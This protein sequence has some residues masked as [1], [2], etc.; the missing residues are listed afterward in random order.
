MDPPKEE[1]L[2]VFLS[3]VRHASAYLAGL[4]VS[5]VGD[6]KAACEVF[7]RGG[8]PTTPPTSS[9][10]GYVLRMFHMARHGDFELFFRWFR[11]DGLGHVDRLAVTH[12]RMDLKA[13]REHPH[14]RRVH[15]RSLGHRPFR[16]A[17]QHD[18]R[19]L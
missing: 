15:R 9:I 8:S 16:C 19:A 17:A 14:V 3:V 11:R 18:P 12:D 2:R 1:P 6:S 13:K 7:R 4:L 10:L 5:V